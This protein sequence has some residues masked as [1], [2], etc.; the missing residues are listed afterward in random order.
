M[1]P[2]WGYNKYTAKGRDLYQDAMELD[3]TLITDP[4]HPTRI[5][6][7]VSRDTSPDLTFV[8]NDVRGAIT[9][10]NTG[11]DLGSDHTIVEISIPE[12]NDTSIKTHRWIDWDAFRDARSQKTDA[13]NEIEVIESWTA[14]IIRSVRTVTKEIETDAAIDKADSRLAHLIEAKQSILSCWKK[15]RLNRRCRKKVAEVN[16]AIEEHCRVLC[17]QQWIE[18]CNAADGSSGTKGTDRLAKL[19]HRAVS[20]HCADEV[21]R[22][23]KDKYLPTTPT[24]QHAPYGGLPNAKLDRDIDVKE[25]RAALHDLNSRSAAGPDLVTNKALKILDDGLIENLA[26]YFNKCWRAAALP[27]Q[28]KTA[29][30]ILIPKPGKLPDTENLR[31]ISLTSYLGKALEH[32]LLNRWQDYLERE[33]LYPATV[34]G[35]R[36]HLSTQDAMLQ[37][38]YKIIHDGGSARDNKAILGLDLKSAFDNVKHSE[39]LSQITKLNMG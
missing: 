37:L 13:D 28:W 26:K 4:T 21:T 22:R 29:K 25:V 36:Q 3:F 35:F 30:T 5:G 1:N 15:Q 14:E 20:L 19:I 6:N 18:I 38:K 2:A 31:P 8:K 32:V 9:W 24:A 34:I 33:G 39:I 16:R 12:H 7:S 23:I 11:T 10:R 17:T 27:K